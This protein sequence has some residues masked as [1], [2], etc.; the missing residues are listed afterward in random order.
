MVASNWDAYFQKVI[1]YEGT[2]Y[3]DIPGDA[4]G[5]TKYGCTIYDVAELHGVK[6]PPRG[7][8]GWFDL[9][10]RVKALDL[11]TV[12]E[13][14]KRKYWD[15][16]RCDDLPSGLDVAVCDWN[17][18]SGFWAIE[19]LG[20]LLG[21]GK[22]RVVTPQMVASV[23]TYGSLAELITNYQDCRRK[24]Y[25]DISQQ[26]AKMKFR[27]GWLS[28]EADCRRY[29]LDLASRA[30]A[31][32]N[33]VVATASAKAIPDTS[34]APADTKP[35][36][37]LTVARKSTSVWTGLT[38]L[39]LTAFAH[40]HSAVQSVGD[41]VRQVFDQLPDIVHASRDNVQAFTDLGQT[42]GAA[43]TI[44]AVATVLG[45][46]CVVV[47]IVRHVDFKHSALVQQGQQS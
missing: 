21:C 33:P 23:N 13:I 26:P 16:C 12:H 1:Q 10:S 15:K 47:Q 36:T 8:K 35:L 2:T 20:E 3:T 39:G 37:K 9:V 25:E 17:I 41:T 34:S 32:V 11:R 43:D 4:G 29:A 5:P 45:A 22:S 38:G 14:F 31:A 19:P 46:V 44:A 27:K 28:R 30:P 18:N 40:L 7:T 24:F 6:V 42:V